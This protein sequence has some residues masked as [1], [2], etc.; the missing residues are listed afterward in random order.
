M[1]TSDWNGKISGETLTVN[2][3][4]TSAGMIV[5]AS[6]SGIAGPLLGITAGMTVDLTYQG[7]KALH[8]GIWNWAN[9]RFNP[10]NWESY[11][12]LGY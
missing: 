11:F 1:P 5:G 3:L 8:T 9:Y 6:I 2:T 4:S 10:T 12:N 7:I